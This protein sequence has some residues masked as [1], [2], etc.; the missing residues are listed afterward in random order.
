MTELC[1]LATKYG[2]DKA[3][4]YT[5]VYDLLLSGR[6]QQVKKVLEIG[7]GTVEAMKHVPGYQPG[8]SLRMWREYFPHA[9]VFGADIVPGD[10]TDTFWLD[11]GNPA[12]LAMLAN[13]LGPFDLVIDDGSHDPHHQV[14][15]ALT[16]LPY[17]TE[18]GLYI[19]EDVNNFEEIAEGLGFG[20]LC[21]SYPS[22]Y[23]SAAR[24]MVIRAQH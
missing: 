11:Q 17:L 14:L 23:K 2:T 5:P 13:K 10:M 8:A 15:G 1:L 24:C 22:P 16:L 21:I 19:I 12:Q 18:D 20:S 4:W 6:R 9:E 7:I 3:G